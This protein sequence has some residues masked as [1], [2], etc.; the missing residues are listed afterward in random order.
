M[1]GGECFKALPRS[2]GASPENCGAY[3][4]ICGAWPLRRIGIDRQKPAK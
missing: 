1:S 4:E 3:R 2:Y